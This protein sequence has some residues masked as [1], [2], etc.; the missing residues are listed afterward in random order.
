MNTTQFK[1]IRE[2]SKLNYRQLGEILGLTKKQVW[3]LEMGRSEIKKTISFC[4]INLKKLEKYDD[5]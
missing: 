4:M 3:N 1:T 5:E 2:K